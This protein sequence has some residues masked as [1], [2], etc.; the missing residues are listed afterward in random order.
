MPYQT[1]AINM[2]KGE[3]FVPDFLTIN[4]NNKIPAIVDT[5]GPGDEPASI[6]ESD[7][8]L[9]YL[10]EKAGCFFP[11]DARE[12]IA[13]LEWLMFQ[14]GGIGPLLG[15]NHHFWL[16]APEPIDYAIACYTNEAK[17]LYGVL[18]R[19]L[20]NREF[21]IGDYSIVDIAIFP[22]IRNHAR[23]GIEL[24]EFPQIGRW[25]DAIKVR[26]AV[27][28]GLAVPP[29]PR[30]EGGYKNDPAAW[31]TPFGSTQYERR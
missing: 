26:P 29:D 13:G 23:Q 24:A 15:Q 14:M 27:R 3:Q 17:R 16:Y 8:I 30:P 4:P 22:W 11:S 1:F 7:A 28:R 31:E 19:R 20:E 12:R 18:D 2:G 21:V 6:F 5:H 25:F 10:A 9:L